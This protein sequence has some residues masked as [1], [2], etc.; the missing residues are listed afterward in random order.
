MN[1]LLDKLDF[2]EN[3]PFETLKNIIKPEH[4]VCNLPFDYYT[5]A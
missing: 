1:I 3:R 5:L 4:K 2:N